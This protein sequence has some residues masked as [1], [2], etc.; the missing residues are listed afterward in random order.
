MSYS[1]PVLSGAASCALQSLSSTLFE[2]TEHE[3]IV[4]CVRAGER[5]GESSWIVGEAQRMRELQMFSQ[6]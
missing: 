5:D 2:T 1:T 3:V 4:S 6:W